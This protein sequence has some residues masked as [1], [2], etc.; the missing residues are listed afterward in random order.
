LGPKTATLPPVSFFA[1]DQQ[2][3]RSCAQV[4]DKTAHLSDSAAN[5]SSPAAERS[6]CIATCP[7]R[8][9]SFQADIQPITERVRW[10]LGCRRAGIKADCDP[11]LP[12][13][14]A[15]CGLWTDCP[16]RLWTAR[17]HGP[18]GIARCPLADRGP[19]RPGPEPTW[20]LDSSDWI[21]SWPRLRQLGCQ[22]PPN[23]AAHFHPTLCSSCCLLLL[24]LLL[25][26]LGVDQVQSTSPVLHQ[27]H[28]T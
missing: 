21:G 20:T 10:L 19:R 18:G 5:S 1:P 17:A 25:P 8:L 9:V 3:N 26:P 24:L 16:A 11:R 2:P 7:S 22:V 23:L 12:A 13:P 27:T 6:I 28:Q 15:S 14:A 4:K